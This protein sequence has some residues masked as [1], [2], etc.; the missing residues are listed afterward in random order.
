MNPKQPA[1]KQLEPKANSL[2]LLSLFGKSTFA[3]AVLT[4]AVLLGAY[5]I[6][7]SGLSGIFQPKDDVSEKQ[8]QERQASFAA[9]VALPVTLVQAK[10]IAAAVEGMQ[11]TPELK[12]ALMADLVRPAVAESP[13][14][15]L[16]LAWITLWDTDAEDGDTVRID[17]Q[18]YSRTVILKKEPVTFAVP[19]LA[20]GTINVAGVSDGDGG[21][22]TVGVASGAAKAVFP[23]MSE[24]Q[25]LGLRVRIN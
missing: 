3:A 14:P 12:Q 23:V 13:A 5:G 25:I 20:D 4:G 21:G 2:P 8:R 9:I 6:N 1:Q 17:S 11:L 10:D 16:H 19:V 15:A 7:G 24:G 22:I 18:G